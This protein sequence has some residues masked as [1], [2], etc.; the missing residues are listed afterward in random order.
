MIFHPLVGPM[1]P[2][3][4]RRENLRRTCVF[5][6]GAIFGSHSAFRCIWGMKHRHTIFHGRARLVRFPQNARLDT[7]RKTCVFASGA[8]R[9]SRSAFLCIRS[10]KQQRIIFLAR[11]VPKQ[12]PQ[13]SAS[14]H[15]TLNLCFCIRCNVWAP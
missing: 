12:F 8:I 11:V 4:A 1:F 15:V 5:A 2:Q 3:K 13:K 9:G 6:L 7:L 14:E 10:M